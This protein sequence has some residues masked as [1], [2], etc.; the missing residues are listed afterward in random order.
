[1]E[2]DSGQ[3]VVGVLHSHIIPLIEGLKEKLENGIDV[4]DVGCGRARAILNLAEAYPNSRFTGFDLSED[5]IEY[6]QSVATSRGLYNIRILAK[7]LSDFDETAQED[8]ADMV[9]SFDAIHDQV[10]PDRVLKGIHRT[11]RP[12][13]TYLM[14]DI[15]AS[16]NVAKNGDHPLGAMLYTLSCCHCMTVSLAQ[17]GMGVG[18]MWGEELTREFLGNAGFEKVDKRVLEHDIQNYYYICKP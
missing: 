18:A 4:V 11:L 13:G 6:A 12:G 3:S 5:A 7:D 8:S 14:Q 15:G 10:R 16:S 17:G 1:M 9:F 2:E